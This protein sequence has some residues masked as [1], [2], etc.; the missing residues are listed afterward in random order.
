[1]ANTFIKIASVTV[2][3]GGAASMDFTSI[4]A[5]YTDLMIK[6]SARGSRTN[7]GSLTVSLRFNSDGGANYSYVRL[8]ADGTSAASDSSTGESYGIAGYVSKR[9]STASTF[10]SCEVYVPNYAGSTQKSYSS[11]G[12]E[13]TN[14]TL[15]YSSIV[16][17]LWT[18]TS[19][20]T[21]IS[22]YASNAIFN[23]DEYSSATLYGIKKD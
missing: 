8:Y 3:S 10:G 19:A 12:V 21:A 20:I 16:A 11:D 1:M 18:G 4:P 6:I 5:T 17:G 2:G 9:F 15:A 23:W 14:A 7:S 22:L 13:E